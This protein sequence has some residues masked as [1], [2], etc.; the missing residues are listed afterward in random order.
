MRPINIVRFTGIFL[1]LAFYRRI[2][3]CVGAR[4]QRSCSFFI[5]FPWVIARFVVCRQ[6]C[7]CRGLISNLR[8]FVFPQTVCSSLINFFF[9]MDTRWFA[10]CVKCECLA[11]YRVPFL[12][13]L[14]LFALSLSFARA[15]FKRVYERVRTKNN[16]KNNGRE[17]SI[18]TIYAICCISSPRDIIT[19]E[20]VCLSF[21]SEKKVN[22]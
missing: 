18:K 13:F 17:N 4:D 7:H 8:F 15:H 6:R 3:F 1:F 20:A 9:I 19:S 10:V 11:A 12:N 16:K 22:K 2:S 14:F 21:Y 5:H